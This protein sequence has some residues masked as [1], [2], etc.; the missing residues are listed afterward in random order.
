MAS[1]MKKQ[2]NDFVTIGEKMDTNI[3]QNTDKEIWRQPT[4]R[5]SDGGL[6][7]GMEPHVFVT[8]GGGI[9]FNYYGTCV[10][11]TIEEWVKLANK[12]DETYFDLS[13][14]KKKRIIKKAARDG[15]E[16][17]KE[18]WTKAIRK[19]AILDTTMELQA[20]IARL[21]SEINSIHWEMV[22]VIALVCIFGWGILA[23][24]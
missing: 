18:T 13:D 4:T 2:T 21:K 12:N 17:Q 11:R 1:N 7:S 3:K 14:G 19:Q 22:L 9:G 24:L 10:V 23:S 6:D 20:E 16:M 15:A 5:N 8:R